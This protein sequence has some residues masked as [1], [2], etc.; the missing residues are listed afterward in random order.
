MPHWRPKVFRRCWTIRWMGH[1]CRQ[2]VG[3]LAKPRE[4]LRPLLELRCEKLKNGYNFLHVFLSNFTWRNLLQQ[5]QDNHN[6]FPVPFGVT[7]ISGPTA[8]TGFGPK[9][10]TAAKSPT[11]GTKGWMSRSTESPNDPQE[12]HDSW[13]LKWLNRDWFEIALAM[14]LLPLRCNI[15]DR[16]YQSHRFSVAKAVEIIGRFMR[17]CLARRRLLLRSSSS[18]CT[19]RESFAWQSME[20]AA[21][22][23]TI[24]QLRIQILTC[25]WKT[26]SNLNL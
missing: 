24:L 2:F 16:T 21:W 4:K 23:I 20:C 17:G 8:S 14:I 19:Y 7:A 1:I 15:E 12:L 25:F 5:Q 26:S 11:D 6:Q 22:R 9:M 3:T 10:A 18:V 13:C